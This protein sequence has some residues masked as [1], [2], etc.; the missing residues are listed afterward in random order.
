MIYRLKVESIFRLEKIAMMK[1]GIE[2]TES[3]A[4]VPMLK[5]IEIPFRIESTYPVTLEELLHVLENMIMDLANPRKQRKQ[6]NLEAV[7]TFDFNDYLVKFEQ[8]VKS[9]EEMIFDIV[10]A[11]GFVLF[12]RFTERMNSIE[13]VRCFIAVLYLAMKGLVI[14]DQEDY[15]DFM[16]S[17]SKKSD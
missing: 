6:L 9:Y 5:P 16:I 12:R 2:V 17:Y 13:I 7:E 3:D 4:E 1:R 14:I 11:D 10:S 15:G 8:I